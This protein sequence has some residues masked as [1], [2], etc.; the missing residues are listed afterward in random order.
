MA[1]DDPSTTLPAEQQPHERSESVAVHPARTVAGD[2]VGTVCGA[3]IQRRPG[4]VCT[5]PPVDGRRRCAIHG[6]KTPQGR[7][8][9]HFISGRFVRYPV[10]LTAA[11]HERL[12]QYTAA[13]YDPRREDL[14]EEL[15]LARI[16][17]ERA[18]AAGGSGVAEGAVVAR[19]AEVHARVRAARVLPRVPDP[20]AIDM[21][22]GI[23]TDAAEEVLFEELESDLAR[24]VLWRMSDLAR[25]VDWSR[26][27]HARPWN[28]TRGS[29]PGGWGRRAETAIT[30][31]KREWSEARA[32]QSG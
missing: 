27:N 29:P 31:R 32:T 12:R 11:E 2:V 9:P 13:V 5:D 17:R 4:E 6:G 21:V 19:L 8:S 25:N 26:V 1:I 10:P 18:I 3:R 7:E 23:A 28:L 20:V 15:A 30:R 16:Q 14:A 24:Y 22:W